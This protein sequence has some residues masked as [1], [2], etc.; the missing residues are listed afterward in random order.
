MTLLFLTGCPSSK[1]VNTYTTKNGNITFNIT[2][3]VKHSYNI[4]VDRVFE[5]GSRTNVIA[6]HPSGKLI[7]GAY[8]NRTESRETHNNQVLIS[9][10]AADTRDA[11]FYFIYGSWV[12]TTY[13]Q[14]VSILGKLV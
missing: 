4:L 7:S 10:R 2:V 3:T 1:T 11:G 5:N 9:I 14:W 12:K 8:E 6:L 13:C